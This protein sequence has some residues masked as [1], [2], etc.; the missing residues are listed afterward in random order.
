MTIKEVL[1]KYINSFNA[2]YKKHCEIM[3]SV[4]ANFTRR[5]EAN[6]NDPVYTQEH[7][8]NW[9]YDITNKQIEKFNEFSKNLNKELNS[10]LEKEYKTITNSIIKHN[11]SLDYATKINNAIQFLQAE[12][13]QLTDDRANSILADFKG[14]FSTMDKFYNLIKAQIGETNFIDTNGNSKFKQTFAETDKQKALLSTLSDIK[15]TAN[16]MFL[17]SVSNHKMQYGLTDIYL[18]GEPYIRIS[19]GVNN[20]NI[21]ENAEALN[22]TISE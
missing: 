18:Y 2:E 17:N 12:K 13:D 8:V 15:E 4:N 10:E 6:K 14:D 20:I 3:Q 21:L 11:Q 16:T 22:N 1:E 7:L 19:Q 9:Y 5:F